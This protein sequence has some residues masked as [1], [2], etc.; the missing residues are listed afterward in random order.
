M[1]AKKV[2]VLLS[3]G[4]KN[5]VE[6]IKKQFDR[7]LFAEEFNRTFGGLFL[8]EGFCSCRMTDYG[9]IWFQI[10]DR[11]SEFNTEGMCVGSGSAVGEAEEWAIKRRK[12]SNAKKT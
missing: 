1:A 11:D 2:V 8:P 4:R 6:K 12:E 5:M 3:R 10:G 9:T 7:E